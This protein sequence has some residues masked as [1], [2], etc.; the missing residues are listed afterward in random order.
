[1][2]IVIC[3]VMSA[4]FSATE[5]AFN[6]VN[7]IKLQNRVSKGS[8]K[9]ALVLK[10][11]EQYDQFLSTILIG[12]NIVNIAATSVATVLC[13]R[14]WGDDAGSAISTVIT[15]ILLLIFGEIS[16]K[17]IAKS[18]AEGYSMFSANPVR[19]F[20][21]ILRP[22]S[23]LFGLWQAVLQKIFKTKDSAGMADEEILT[24][25]K[26][27]QTEGEIDAQES[28][29][30][31]NSIDFNDTE[32]EDILTP[33]V[34]IIA[35]EN[36]VTNEEAAE[37]FAKSGFSRLPVYQDDIDHIIG[38]L[39]IKDFYNKAFREGEDIMDMIRPV[40][41]TTEH[42]P[43]GELFRELQQKKLHV[44]VVIDEYGGTTGL[45]TVED[46]LEEL[47]GEI[48]DEHEEIVK[49][50]QKVSEDEYNVSGSYN[51][52]KLLEKFD[53]QDEE[54][55]DA[56]TVSGWVSDALDHFP[57]AGDEVTINRMHIRVV[58]VDERR[59]VMVRI[60]LLPKPEPK[61]KE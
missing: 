2:V 31:H 18:H 13:V 29:L 7:K 60:R 59:I 28:T 15:T 20:M 19:F 1:L 35:V 58:K 38:I 22:F 24:I 44:A 46:I 3:V 30:I 26:A 11:L 27:A 42:R 23:A 39:Y 34:D 10:I 9:A 55:P 57:H 5:T 12:N 51:V 8:A 45:V 17:T 52:D 32:A 25:V 53:I 36:T 40:V 56:L 54:E 47:V 61:E 33:R 49:D 48:W 41:Y 14:R 50:I 16:P 21:V 4:F 37:V 43:I 6:S